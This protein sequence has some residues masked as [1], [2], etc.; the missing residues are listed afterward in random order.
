M[1]S[2]LRSAARG[3]LRAASLAHPPPPYAAARALGTS[4]PS[5]G[6]EEFLNQGLKHGEYP[7]AGTQAQRMRSHA[8]SCRNLTFTLRRA[9]VGGC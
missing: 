6:V 8:M 3:A 2:A 1:L 4:R 7:K 9:R 5:L